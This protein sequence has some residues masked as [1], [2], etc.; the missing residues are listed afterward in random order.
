MSEPRFAEILARIARIGAACGVDVDTE[1]GDTQVLGEVL[2]GLSRIEAAIA[3][4]AP[5]SGD[6][7]RRLVDIT[8]VIYGLVQLDF[9]RRVSVAE[10]DDLINAIA[11][12][13]NCLG[14]ELSTRAVS[15]AF[16][17]QVIESMQDALVVTNREGRITLA[18]QAAARLF[19]RSMELLAGEPLQALLPQISLDELRGAGGVTDR[20]SV[21]MT[22]DGRTTPISLTLSLLQDAAAG[23]QGL[24]CVAR[25]QTER[26]REEQERWRLREEVQRQT[27]LMEELSTPLIPISD[28]VL[29]M[30]LIGKIDLRRCS[31]IF[32]TLLQGIVERRASVAILDVTGVHVMDTAALQGIMQ[33]V[34]GSRLIGAQ[35][36]ITGIRPEVARTLVELQVDLRDIVT[37][38]TLQDGVSHAIR[39]SR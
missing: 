35:V 1:I 18:N 34:Q 8:D 3:V 32:E 12:G 27:I 7:H 21:C 11:V 19:G 6:V 37:F 28:K 13:V 29:V 25:D 24:V 14:E 33:A 23:A 39:T 15:K 16:V 5:H 2:A 4:Q 9:S 36:I 10:S 26:T 38:R 30:P 17:D 31:L 22:A 20:T